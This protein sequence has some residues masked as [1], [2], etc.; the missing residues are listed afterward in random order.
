MGLPA[1]QFQ[2]RECAWHTKFR[3]DGHCDNPGHKQPLQPLQ[4][5]QL[6]Q[7]GWQVER[8]V[9]AIRLQSSLDAP[10]GTEALETNE[11]VQ[12]THSAVY[13]PCISFNCSGCKQQL[14]DEA[15]CL[16]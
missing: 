3:R 16:G 7:L 4:P 6:R 8:F 13:V 10:W 14:G 1:S 11:A 9:G 5:L 2:L 15:A 12:D